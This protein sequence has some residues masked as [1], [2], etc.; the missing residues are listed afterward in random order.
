MKDGTGHAQAVC[1][2]D[3]VPVVGLWVAV[4]TLTLTANS[5]CLRRRSSRSEA[6]ARKNV[7]STSECKA[8]NATG[9]GAASHDATVVGQEAR[10]RKCG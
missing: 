10:P 7:V 5:A 4:R 8:R 1:D 6:R 2:A 9:V 3:G